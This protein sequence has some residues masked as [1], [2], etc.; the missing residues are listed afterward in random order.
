MA[1]SLPW[2]PF[3]VPDSAHLP[4]QQGPPNDRQAQGLSRPLRRLNRGEHADLTTRR[5]PQLGQPDLGSSRQARS[6]P[7]R[8]TALKRA[9]CA[10]AIGAL[11]AH[12]ARL[13]AATPPSSTRKQ[14]RQ[15]QRLPSLQAKCSRIGLRRASTG[16]PAPSALAAAGLAP[17]AAARAALT[18]IKGV[19]HH[20][21]KPCSLPISFAKL[22]SPSG[23]GSPPLCRP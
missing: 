9:L 13:N 19:S 18:S 11:P 1:V 3:W 23:Q 2:P 12:R 15:S 22:V 8:T 7:Y 14:F 5:G 20:L 6:R 17:S 4:A 21:R 16:G 10:S